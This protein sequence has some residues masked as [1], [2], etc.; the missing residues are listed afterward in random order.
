MKILPHAP[1]AAAMP[2]PVIDNAQELFH[3]TK[4]Q[5]AFLGK[6]ARQIHVRITPKP[7]LKLNS[8]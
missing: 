7:I 3:C 8:A 4:C 2:T 5:Q 1:A 6:G